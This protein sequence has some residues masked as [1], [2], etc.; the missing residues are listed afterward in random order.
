MCCVPFFQGLGHE[1]DGRLV[2]VL[3]QV[4][5]H[6]VIRGVDLAALEPFPA[7][8]VAGVQDIIPVFVPV[9]QVGI[10]FEAIGKVVKAKTIIDRRIRHVCLCDKL[11]G[12]II[13]FFFTPVNRDLRF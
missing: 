3:G 6:A 4:A 12:G 13:V 11:I 8:R 9:Q 5:V 2:L 1:V 7:G 10:F